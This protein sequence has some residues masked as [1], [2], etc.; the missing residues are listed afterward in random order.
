MEKDKYDY[1]LYKKIKN[2]DGIILEYFILS[3]NLFGY[4]T[5]KKIINIISIK[6]DFEFVLKISDYNKNDLKVISLEKNS[7]ELATINDKKI[8][9]IE[10]KNKNENYSYIKKVILKQ[11]DSLEINCITKLKEIPFFCYAYENGEIYIN[12]SITPYEKKTYFEI[13]NQLQKLNQNNFK[14]ITLNSLKNKLF[15]GNKNGVLI[16][17]FD[18]TFKFKFENFYPEI[19]LDSPTLFMIISQNKVIMVNKDFMILYN[20]DS[21]QIEIKL[22]YPGYLIRGCFIPLDEKIVFASC[23]DKS[24]RIFDINTFKEVKKYEKKHDNN[25]SCYFKIGNYLLFSSLQLYYS[26]NLYCYKNNF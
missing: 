11:K 18:N 15:I 9:I 4:F 21:S 1:S 26:D 12:S 14:I 19:F 7:N 22:A 6:K 16:Y 17:S 8:E 20:V 23:D 2:D 5:D 10:I 13:N 24:F 3:E 25:T